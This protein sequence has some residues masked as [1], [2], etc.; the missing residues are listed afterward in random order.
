[1]PVLLMVAQGSGQG[2]QAVRWCRLHCL[3]SL[4]QHCFLEG[5][6]SPARVRACVPS[7]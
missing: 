1:M 3:V 5:P 4:S 6:R 2:P 7:L